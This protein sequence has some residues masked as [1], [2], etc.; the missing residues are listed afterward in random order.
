LEE[1][2]S[3]IEKQCPYTFSGHDIEGNPSKTQ[4]WHN[5]KIMNYEKHYDNS[6]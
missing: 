2:Y 3:D 1:D 4:L 5:S 6:T